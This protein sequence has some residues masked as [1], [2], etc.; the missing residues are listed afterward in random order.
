MVEMEG[1]RKLPLILGRPFLNTAGASM[2]YPNKRT[3]LLHVGE[4]FYYPITPTTTPL[5]GTITHIKER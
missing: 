1:T 5:C 2:D 4:K 3:V